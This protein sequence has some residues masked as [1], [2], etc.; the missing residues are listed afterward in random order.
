MS[1]DTDRDLAKRRENAAKSTAVEQIELTLEQ[2]Q[3]SCAPEL[4]ATRKEDLK[5][6]PLAILQQLEQDVQ[7]SN[8]SGVMHLIVKAVSDFRQAQREEQRRRDDEAGPAIMEMY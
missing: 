7:A 1:H 3:Y 8:A 6:L 4:W 5:T 2:L